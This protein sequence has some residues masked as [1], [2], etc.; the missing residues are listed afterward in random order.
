[1]ITNK[2]DA[3]SIDI[4]VNSFEIKKF[5]ISRV[6]DNNINIRRL[7]ASCDIGYEDFNSWLNHP[8]IRYSRRRISHYK[9]LAMLRLLGCNLRVQVVSD[10]YPIEESLKNHVKYK[11]EYADT[12]KQSLAHVT[13]RLSNITGFVVSAHRTYQNDGVYDTGDS[14]GGDQ[15]NAEKGNQGFDAE[16]QAPEEGLG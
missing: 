3:N 11:R 2:V 12:Q 1:M 9:I 5:I 16:T 15:E 10:Q 4:I 6:K 14:S 13:E 8:S 7:L